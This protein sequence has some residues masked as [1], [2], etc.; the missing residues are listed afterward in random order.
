MPR[1]DGP[2]KVVRAHLKT[3][4]YTLKLPFS[5]VKVDGF[6]GRLLKPW[7]L[8]NPLLFP[9]QQLPEPAPILNPDGDAEWR[10]E[11]IVDVRKQGKG[12]QYLVRYV[13]YGPEDDRW[14]PGAEV[15]DLEALEKWL[16]ENPR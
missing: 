10:V 4:S 11:K 1:Y 7:K 9:D 8:N 3:S 16:E 12:Y 13:G 6:H 2:Y 5:D 15:Q 14:L